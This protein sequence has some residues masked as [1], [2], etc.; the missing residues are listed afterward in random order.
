VDLELRELDMRPAATLL[1][2]LLSL[3]LVSALAA[4]SARP[5]CAAAEL[6]R[7]GLFTQGAD[8]MPTDW[9]TEAYASGPK[10][11][12]Y[13]WSVDSLGI[14]TIAITSHQPNDARFVQIVPVSPS[15]WYRI[16]A[17]VQTEDVGANQIG[18]Y[19]SVMDTFDNSQDLR[20]TAAWQMVS[21]W[22]YTGALETS[23]KVACRLGGYGALNSGTA[24]FT[25]MSVAAA[26]KPSPE[27][28]YVYG[29]STAQSNE[30]RLP[31]VRI[32]AIFVAVGVAALVWRYLLPR[33]DDPA[34]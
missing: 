13:G 1:R 32:A 26:G 25:G 14:G 17:W 30:S 27:T 23:L 6:V 33:A 10:S 15:T 18:A 24:R 7:N 19:L 12:E 8:D 5:A 3:L 21:L 22:I 31:W 4:G 16:S 28:P 29:G 20:G 34:S 9:K 2:A 11:T